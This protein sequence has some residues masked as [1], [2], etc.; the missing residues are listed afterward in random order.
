MEVAD[1]DGYVNFHSSQ[2]VRMT[3]SL[4]DWCEFSPK[5]STSPT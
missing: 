1:Y 3:S 2:N 5:I 4:N